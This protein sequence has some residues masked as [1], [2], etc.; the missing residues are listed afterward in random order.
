MQDD[1]PSACGVTQAGF[2]D[3]ERRKDYDAVVA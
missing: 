1:M 3:R 2:W